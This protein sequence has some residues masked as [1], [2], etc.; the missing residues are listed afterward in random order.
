VVGRR[1][2]SRFLAEAFREK[3]VREAQARALAECAG[4][5]DLAQYPEW[6]TREDV[7]RWVRKSRRL[8]DLR[9]PEAASVGN[10]P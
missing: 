9:A 7:S 10:R 6:R 4:V 3:I 8:D 5:I 1:D 2:R